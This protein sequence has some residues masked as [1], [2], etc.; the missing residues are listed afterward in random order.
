[1]AEMKFKG[2]C[3]LL[4]TKRLILEESLKIMKARL[5]ALFEGLKV[6]RGFGLIHH[7]DKKY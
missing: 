7:A 4:G 6:T 3:L 2:P 5:N 1:M